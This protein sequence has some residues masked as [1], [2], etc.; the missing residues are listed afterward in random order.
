MQ[1][2]PSR[3][4]LGC[5]VLLRSDLCRNPRV[6]GEMTHWRGLERKGGIKFRTNSSDAFVFS[7]EG[8]SQ[9]GKRNGFR[10]L[11]KDC[12]QSVTISS[13]I[14][15]DKA[16]VKGK[17][18]SKQIR[19]RCDLHKVQISPQYYVVANYLVRLLVVGMHYTFYGAELS[20]NCPVI[21]NASVCVS[22]PAPTSEN[23]SALF[24]WW[25]FKINNC[26]LMW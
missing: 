2:N 21:T 8:K 4:S 7:S 24:N 18:C 16:R 17:Y 3:P 23:S 12:G 10:I 15:N 19:S 6:R 9:I 20:S 25:F 1:L 22:V 14:R 26:C 11:G 5:R 13:W